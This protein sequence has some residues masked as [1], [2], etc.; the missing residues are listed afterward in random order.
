[1]L[2]QRATRSLE[3]VSGNTLQIIPMPLSL[4]LDLKPKWSIQIRSQCLNEHW[5]A[6]YINIELFNNVL[7]LVKHII[8][9]FNATASNARS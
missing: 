2:G 9:D 7:I 3:R 6:P 1:M 4:I 5:N 8:D